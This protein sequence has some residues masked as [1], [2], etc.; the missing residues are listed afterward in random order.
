MKETEMLKKNYEFRT[1]LTKGH[2][3]IGKQ[4][5]VVI[6]RNRKKCKLLGIAISAKNGKNV[7]EL[8]KVI[9]NNL[10]SDIKYFDDDIF[11]DKSI[12]F[13]V[14]EII[15]EKALLYLQDE[16]PHGIAVDIV[17]FKEDSK[18][19][20]IDADIICEREAHKP[21][22]L[23]RNGEMI[24]KIGTA[25]RIDIENLVGLKVYLSLFVKVRDNW[26]NNFN[27]MNNLGYTEE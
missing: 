26:R 23:G 8:I 21:I 24:K 13:M 25:S 19:V 6:L 12:R 9:K 17:E 14:S 27:Q 22:I 18:K 7:D 3:F 10:T 16:I 20:I 1:V 2:F 15:R 5:K 4:L 11:T